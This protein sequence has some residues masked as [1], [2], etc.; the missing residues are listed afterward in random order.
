[1]LTSALPSTPARS[2][3]L[4]VSVLVVVA[5]FI[6]TI[7]LQRES[8]WNDEA[9]TAWA[10]R[11]PYLRDTLQRVQADVHPPLYF[12]LLGVLG[13][14]TGDSVL[15]LRW[16]S[17]LF[18]ML[19]LASTYAV[20]KRLFDR[21]TAII[22]L[23][24][25]GSAS[26]F[27]YYAREARMYSLLMAL[28]AL[29]TWLYLRWQAKPSLWRSLVYAVSMALLMYTHYAGAL[30]IL[31][32]LLHALISQ[33]L[34]RTRRPKWYA[35][36]LPYV[37]ALVFYLPWLPIFLAQMRSN[38]NGP[39]AIPVPTDWAT[40]AA[41]VLI[42]TGGNWWL[43]AAPFV[44]GTAVPRVRQHASQITLLLLWLLVTPIGL[45]ALNQWF[46]P[47][48]QVRYAIAML[49]AGALLLAYGLRHIH[50][51]AWLRLGAVR[52]LY[53]ATAITVVLLIWIAAVQLTIYHE[54]WP[55][56]P[57]WQSTISSMIAAR[58]PL[59]ATITDLA[60]YSPAAYYDRQLGLRRGIGLDLSWRLHTPTEVR[61]LVDK[62]APS[63]SIWITLPVNTTKSWQVAA[64]LD[65]ERG[66]SYRSSLGNMVFY[67]FNGD[68]TAN[69]QYQFGDTVRLVGQLP[70]DEGFTITAGNELC[71]DLALQTLT[72]TDD[73]YSVGLHLV[74]ITGNLN[75]AQW[76]NGFGSHPAGETVDLSPC[77]PIST[78]TAPGSYHLELT[79]YKWATVERLP[80]F[81]TGGGTP[82]GWGDVVML[83]SVE[84]RAPE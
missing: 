29:S 81:E 71:V 61:A 10:V 66:I 60:A 74:D 4:I 54:I 2:N 83:Q 50:I 48:Y 77:L 70:S 69:L 53:V 72:A 58:Q 56:K 42:V 7:D 84:V 67:N 19:A 6:A 68:N 5:F 76:D 26:F 80:V 21:R 13:R 23:I 14:F 32:H 52:S 75:A 9:W 47:V 82:V 16:P 79:F 33:V 20:G 62:L 64:Q 3:I 36:P 43:I 27:V 18:A 37:A 57:A 39:L 8:L 24:L 11:S 31:S 25:L 28:A 38:P 49:P 46:A 17:A 65:R 44:L 30:V 40:V 12:L 41:L 45:L 15:A 55:P 35:L 59:D 34:P 51:P 73:S 63:D 78:A 1:V 22:A